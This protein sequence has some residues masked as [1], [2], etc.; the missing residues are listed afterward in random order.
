MD[1]KDVNLGPVTPGILPGPLPR[2]QG[3][4]VEIP[5]SSQDFRSQLERASGPTTSEPLKFSNHAIQRLQSRNITLSS[6]DVS[7]MNE[8]A[9]K[10]AAKGSKQSLFMLKDVA[11]VVSITNRTVITA[12]DKDSMKENVFTNIDS[13]AVIN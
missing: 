11:M 5:P 12:V 3:R 8:M 4:P 9:E 13:A 1:P 7:R 10:A 6:D 2:P